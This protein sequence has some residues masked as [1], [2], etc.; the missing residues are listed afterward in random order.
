[1]NRHGNT[2]RRLLKYTS[3]G[4]LRKATRILSG[5]FQ[6]LSDVLL[7]I[8][9]PTITCQ[10]FLRGAERKPPSSVR[11]CFILCFGLLTLGRLLA[12][13]TAAPSPPSDP[14]Y[15]L[16]E[17]AVRLYDQ[18]MRLDFEAA[19]ATSLVIKEKEPGNLAV[20]HL[21]N[22]LDFFRLYLTEDEKLLEALLPRR[23]QRL[24]L[25][26][27][28]PAT[29]PWRNY[30]LAEIRLHWAMIRLRFEAYYPAFRD[31]NKAHKLLRD[32]AR[33]FPD[34]MLT[35]KDLGL[36]H[37]AVGAVPPQFKWGI[38]LF[39]SLNGSIEQGAKEMQLAMVD[40]QHPFYRET[41][42]LYAFLQLH[43]RGKPEAAWQTVSQLNLQARSNKLHCFVLAN[44]AMRSG[45]NDRAIA[46]LEAQPRN[47]NSLDFAY[48]DFMLGLAKI[49][50]LDLSAGLYFQ[51]FL[52]RFDGLHFVKEATQKLAWC[53]L[54]RGQEADY[55]ERLAE[56]GRRGN[57]TN[58]GDANADNEA[59]RGRP[60]HRGLLRAR[61]LF[62]GAYYERARSV[63]DTI[64]KGTLNA[65]ER[66]EHFYRTG[67]IL[68][69]LKEYDGAL[70]FYERTIVE[71]RAAEQ[72]F[73]C[74][75]ALQAGL[76]EEER[77]NDRRAREYFELCL[78]I[79]PSEYKTGLHI[80]A[81]AGLNRLK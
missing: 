36:L 11:Y 7:G 44:V 20:H 52:A 6:R 69:G 13:N 45:R 39:S 68:H 62:D 59:Q 58:G 81:K 55:Y 23:D 65:A 12:E 57:A 71:G 5:R 29:S 28:L 42:V 22:Y 77:G 54:L 49:R 53:A 27:E 75:A 64:D 66:L 51:S 4:P 21:E 19:L 26:S 73:A 50:N 43:L 80:Q 48:L 10:K 16:S 32:N 33:D 31:I 79:S 46:I 1:M 9:W 35:Y 24:A 14:Y 78:D 37:A 41:A 34:F 2:T 61:L 15:A 63:L 18:V 17:R 40:E 74:N 8:I 60:I 25:L 67:R 70:G 72:F 76:I 56:V 3:E 38:E 47:R 30:A